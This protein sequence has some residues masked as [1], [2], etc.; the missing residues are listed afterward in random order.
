MAG[1]IVKIGANTD[2]LDSALTRSKSSVKQFSSDMKRGIATAAKYGAAAAAA[3]AA[4][5]VLVNHSIDAS[6][7]T[8]NLSRLANTSVN[9]F[10]KMAF[11]AKSVGIQQENLADILKDTSDRVGDFLTTGGGPMAD[12]FERIA[13]KVG[14]TAEQFR[15]LSG[16]DALQLYV[17]SLEKA[18]LSQNEMTFFMEAI[19]S[20]ATALLPLLR[21]GGEAMAEQARQ[22]DRLGITL[23]D[24]DSAMIEDAAVQMDKIGSVVSGFASQFTAQLSPVLSAL[25]RQF[26]GLAEDAGGVGNA[27]ATSFNVV[28]DAIATV[29]NAFDALD[30][31]LLQ[32]ETAI[33]TFALAFRIG[34]L[35]VAREIVEIPTA[36]VNEMIGIINNLPGVDVDFLGMSDFGVEITNQITSAQNQINQFNDE[37]D[38]V[39]SEPLSGDKFKRFVADAQKA[40]EDSAAAAAGASIGLGVGG[41]GG[42]D[43]ASDEL[44]EKLEKRLDVIRMANMNERELELEKFA[45][46]NEDLNMA[47]EQQLITRQEWAELSRQQKA[48]EEEALTEIESKASEARQKIQEEEARNKQQI[49]AG[50]LSGLTT[51]MNS[52]SR[53]MFEIG[54]A[55][56]IS[57]S[58][59][60]TYTGATKA[61]E[62]GWPLG[63]IAAAAI[64]ATG[65]AKVASIKSQ[66]FGG[67]SGGA[68]AGGGGAA[69]VTQGVNA[70]SE[71]VRRSTN[72]DISLIGADSRDRAVAGSIISQINE[73][74]E[75]GARINRVA[76]A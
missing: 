7:E 6:R 11:A 47:L 28:V 36:A 52:E 25:G 1:V 9:T 33:D 46:E 32:S 51:L 72:I 55:A 50:A 15:K 34:L 57:Q 63:P 45:L 20:N 58:I 70:Q 19:A 17:D 21:N 29:A 49:M 62:L 59:I 64:T 30:R 44:K 27:A 54:K 53:K 37:L 12:F 60:S 56:A 2:E 71:E 3:G 35:E 8:A 10:G 67:G 13:P 66:S 75:G 76:L 38:R 22:A 40:A 73:E 74:V 43:A 14:V 23:S 48:R 61:L 5:G 69:S 65:F 42:S 68:A 26:L 41:P 4:I 24:I 31:V 16:P 39:L 18:N